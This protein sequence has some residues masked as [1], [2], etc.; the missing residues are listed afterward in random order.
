MNVVGDVSPEQLHHL[1]KIIG[2]LEEVHI[3]STWPGYYYY[4]YYYY[5]YSK[6][7]VNNV[8]HSRNE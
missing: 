8:H 6:T 7:F 3:T 5:Y 2:R 4:Y 1:G